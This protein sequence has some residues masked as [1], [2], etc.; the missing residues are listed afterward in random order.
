MMMEGT[1][2]LCVVL[3]QRE[4]ERECDV[5][6]AELLSSPLSELQISAEFFLTTMHD[7]VADKYNAT[8][9]EQNRLESPSQ[10]EAVLKTGPA[11]GLG[12]FHVKYRVIS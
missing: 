8:E 7:W 4:C 3:N 1:Y 10:S 12:T 2:L 11:C 6:L 5:R 9:Q